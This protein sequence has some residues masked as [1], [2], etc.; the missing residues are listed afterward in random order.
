MSFNKLRNLIKRKKV[1]TVRS[2]GKT[3]KRMKWEYKVVQMVAVTPSDPDDASKKLGGSIS[4]DTLKNEFPE[5]YSNKNGRKQ[6]NDFLNLLGEDGWELVEIQTISELPL[7]VFK[8]PA[9]ARNG[10]SS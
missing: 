5:Y 7:M 1:T 10:N 3:Q 8:R 6:I 9:D 2:S 4:P